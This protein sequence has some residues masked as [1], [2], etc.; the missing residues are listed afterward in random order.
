M[1][2]HSDLSQQIPP[3]ASIST[4]SPPRQKKRRPFD[5]SIIGDSGDGMDFITE[6]LDSSTEYSIIGI[7]LDGTIVLWNE[8]ARRIYGYEP[9]EVIGKTTS[10]I[11][12]TSEDV[13]AGL[14]EK[15][16]AEALA[17]GKFEGTVARNEGTASDLSPT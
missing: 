17:R 14:P 11:L 8:G 7:D 6:I 1:T 3:L 2:T 4:T 15:I 12:H 10:S 9:D 13:E 5:L 16:L